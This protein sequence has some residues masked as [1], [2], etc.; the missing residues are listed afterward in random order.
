M[1]FENQLELGLGIY[2]S[3]EISRILRLPAHKV[4]R[5]INRYWDGELGKKYEGQYSWKTNNSQAVSFH[6]LIEFFVMMQL[7]EQGV[8]TRSLLD[9]HKI[10][11]DRFNSPFPFA[12]KEVLQN[13]RTDGKKIYFVINDDCILSLDGSNQLNL[14][15]IDDFFKNID[16]DS[17]NLA[18]RYWPLGKNNSILID[19]ERKFGHPV[20]G[21]HNI[22]PETIYNHFKGG[23]PAP[24]IAY[25]Y[26]LTEKQVL[27]AL[28]YC[29]AA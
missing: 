20:I 9:G 10:L 15:F 1:N 7:S 5:W 27:D 21:N 26:N 6:T 22:T 29:K 8:R 13:I 19:P 17:E 23:D 11:S 14:A 12:M 16:F 28:E 18:F 24:Y 4:R 2:T 3:T 25:V